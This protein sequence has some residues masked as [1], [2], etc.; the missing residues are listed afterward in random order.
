MK[1]KGL[2]GLVPGEDG[3]KAIIHGGLAQLSGYVGVWHFVTGQHEIFFR[4]VKWRG[5]EGRWRILGGMRLGVHGFRWRGAPRH[6]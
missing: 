5:M 6:I 4:K 3:V 1:M 2:S